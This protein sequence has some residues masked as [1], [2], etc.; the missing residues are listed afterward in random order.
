MTVLEKYNLALDR[1]AKEERERAAQAKACGDERGHSIHLMQ[2]SMLGDMLKA[3][4]RVEHEGLRPGVLQAQI[5]A[6]LCESERRQAQGD[7]DAAD[8]ARVKAETID[9]ARRTLKEMEV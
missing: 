8:R 4:G 1:R 5:D 9:W 2:C 3:L 7:F 6:L